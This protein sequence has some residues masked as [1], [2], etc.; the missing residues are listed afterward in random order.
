MTGPVWNTAGARAAFGGIFSPGVGSIHL[1][2]VACNGDE[3][4][5]SNC[6]SS[7]Q[8]NC[9]HFEDAGVFCEGQALVLFLFVFVSFS[10]FWCYRCVCRSS[11]FVE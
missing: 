10:W 9:R 6:T 3:E 4:S 7:D 2:D 1:D 11:R 8:L 5:I